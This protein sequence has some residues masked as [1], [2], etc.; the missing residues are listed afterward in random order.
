M[1]A[2][3]SALTHYLADT[4]ILGIIIPS[5]SQNSYGGETSNRVFALGFAA[6][7]TCFRQG[8]LWL[9]VIAKTLLLVSPSSAVGVSVLS[10]NSSLLSL[11]LF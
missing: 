10:R 11:S 2:K 3:F 5:V 1:D 4:S 9:Q 8:F 6:G 7:K